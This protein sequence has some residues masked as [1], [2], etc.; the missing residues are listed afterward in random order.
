[1]VE[2]DGGMSI[3]DFEIVAGV[4]GEE[5]LSMPRQGKDR[6]VSNARDGQQPMLLP[7]F[8]APCNLLQ[9]WVL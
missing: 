4:P 8:T 5:A 3:I 6:E 7:V 9:V 2:E 1:V